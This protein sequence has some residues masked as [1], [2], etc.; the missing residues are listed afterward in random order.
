L[1]ALS[2]TELEDWLRAMVR[3]G[4]E[5]SNATFHSNSTF[6]EGIP[7]GDSAS[8]SGEESEV[9]VAATTVADTFVL[10]PTN[11][12]AAD[13]AYAAALASKRVDSLKLDFTTPF[14]YLHNM[15]RP[16]SA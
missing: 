6:Y 16:A 11:P 7:V 15:F 10:S 3:G 2:E 1:A 8:D 5:V 9:A 4:C 13:V 14:A 12:F